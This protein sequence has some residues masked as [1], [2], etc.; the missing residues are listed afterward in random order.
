MC[1][2]P[3]VCKPYGLLVLATD[4]GQVDGTDF[5]LS[6]RAFAEMALPGADKELLKYGTVDVDYKRVPCYHGRRVQFKITK[7]SASPNYLAIIVLYQHGQNDIIGF[8]IWKV[9]LK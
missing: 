4:Y 9:N 3:R 5:I 2:I 8:D 1:S 7:N 6:P